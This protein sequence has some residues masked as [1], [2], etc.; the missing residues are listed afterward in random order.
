MNPT[1]TVLLIKLDNGYVY[2]SKINIDGKIIERNTVCSDLK[3]TYSIEMYFRQ[4]VDFLQNPKF[5]KEESGA[6]TPTTKDD[7]PF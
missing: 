6:D 1:L 4:D 7:A 5:V 2:Q 3:Y